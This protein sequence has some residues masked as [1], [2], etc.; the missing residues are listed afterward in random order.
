[1]QS[2]G[3]QGE[4]GAVKSATLWSNARQI[5]RHGTEL[6]AL[7]QSEEVDEAPPDATQ[8]EKEEPKQTK[9]VAILDTSNSKLILAVGEE[10]VEF[11]IVNSATEESCSQIYDQST[12]A[13]P[14]EANQPLSPV[15]KIQR[16]KLK[17]DGEI[18]LKINSR[19]N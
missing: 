2:I 9:E 15:L 13:N 11:N 12:H 14:V 6:P 16:E 10:K 4:R 8:E 1:M 3:Q 7:V 17:K 5:R 19:K 18:S